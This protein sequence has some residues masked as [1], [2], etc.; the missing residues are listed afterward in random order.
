MGFQVPL[1]DG[2]DPKAHDT[3]GETVL[4]WAAAQNKN[5]EVISTLLKAGADA[6]AKDSA[7]RTAFDYAKSNYSLRVKGTDALKQLEEASK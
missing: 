2:A 6:R 5:P 7:G 4:M 3:S 1:K